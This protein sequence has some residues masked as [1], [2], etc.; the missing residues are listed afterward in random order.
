MVNN[1]AEEV[2]NAKFQD[3]SDGVTLG[4]ATDPVRGWS[5]DIAEALVYDRQLTPTEMQFVCYSLSN[6]YG[7]H[8]T[9]ATQPSAPKPAAAKPSDG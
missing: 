6:K 5:G 7:I 1:L 2:G 3:L 9:T 4:A 8:P